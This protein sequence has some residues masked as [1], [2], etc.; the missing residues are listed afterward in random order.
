MSTWRSRGY[1][2][3]ARFTGCM[4][5]KHDHMEDATGGHVQSQAK[6]AARRAGVGW[7]MVWFFLHL[8]TVYGVVSFCTARPAG[9]RRG[10]LLPL[11][12]H[13]SSAGRLDYLYPRLFAFRFIP[14]FLAD[15]VNA[16][17]KHKAAQFGLARARRDSRLT[18]FE[19]SP[20]ATVLH[21]R[22]SAALPQYRTVVVDS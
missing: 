12:D 5:Y 8:A 9:F 2:A 6:P 15:L 14:P 7:Q 10:V 18:G 3:L 20:P 4:T 22:S 16:R 13:P 19:P 11:L 1:A 17:F 21:S